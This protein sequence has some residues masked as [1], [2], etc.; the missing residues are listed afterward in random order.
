L[1]TS[2][3][4]I[5]LSCGLYV[6][7][8]FSLRDVDLSQELERRRHSASL[9]ELLAARVSGAEAHSARTASSEE[10]Q[11]AKCAEEACRGTS[12]TGRSLPPGVLPQVRMNLNAMLDQRHNRSEEDTTAEHQEIIYIML[13]DVISLPQLSLTFPLSPFSILR[14][15]CTQTAHRCGEEQE[16]LREKSIQTRQGDTPI[17]HSIGTSAHLSFLFTLLCLPCCLTRITIFYSPQ[18]GEGDRRYD[19]KLVKHLNSG[20]SSLGT[21]TIGR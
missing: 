6:Y 4:Y 16:D 12:T 5:M 18:G 17:Q 19:A 2:K 13:L 7:S 11:R 3:Q 20:K 14:I 15:R 8:N 9:P 1:P 10:S 21:S